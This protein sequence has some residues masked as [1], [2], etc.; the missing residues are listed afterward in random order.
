[1]AT[2][3]SVGMLKLTAIKGNCIKNDTLGRSRSNKVNNATAITTNSLR[4][5]RNMR[6]FRGLKE[7]FLTQLSANSDN[8]APGR[9]HMTYIAGTIILKAAK[10]EIPDFI[11]SER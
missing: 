7:R 1:V 11:A 3:T 4:N 6:T 2:I 10:P 5:N 8:T 9:N